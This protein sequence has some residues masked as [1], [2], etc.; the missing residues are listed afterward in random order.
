MATISSISTSVAYVLPTQDT[1]SMDF[2]PDD[3]IAV[4]KATNRSKPSNPVDWLNFK[5]SKK[6]LKEAAKN[7]QLTEKQREAA[8]AAFRGTDAFNSTTLMSKNSTNG[9]FLVRPTILLFAD[10]RL[11]N[12]IMY[13][14]Q[15]P[16]ETAIINRASLKVLEALVIKGKRAELSQNELAELTYVAALLKLPGE[17]KTLRDALKASL[18]VNNE[19]IS[20]R[21]YYI[22][23][24]LNLNLTLVNNTRIYA[25]CAKAKCC[26][27]VTDSLTSLGGELDKFEKVLSGEETK[28]WQS[29]SPLLQLRFFYFLQDEKNFQ[30][31]RLQVFSSLLCY[32]RDGQLDD[33]YVNLLFQTVKQFFEYREILKK[34]RLTLNIEGVGTMD[35]ALWNVCGMSKFFCSHLRS[36]MNKSADVIPLVGS[37]AKTFPILYE[38]W[39]KNR[40]IEVDKYSLD[41][42]VELLEGIGY[43]QIRD[44]ADVRTKIVVAISEKLGDDKLSLVELASKLDCPE[45]NEKVSELFKK[46]PF[47]VFT[48]NGKQKAVKIQFEKFPSMHAL[49]QSLPIIKFLYADKQISNIEIDMQEVP[50]G[51]DDSLFLLICH[52]CC[53]ALGLDEQKEGLEKQLL[54]LSRLETEKPVGVGKFPVFKAFDFL[55]LLEGTSDPL[56]AH[57]IKLAQE[58]SYT[59]EWESTKICLK[60][61]KPQEIRTRMGRF[62][63]IAFD[64]SGVY[65]AYLPAHELLQ[66]ILFYVGKT[67]G[68]HLSREHSLILK[69]ISKKISSCLDAKSLSPT[70][71]LEIIRLCIKLNPI[72]RNWIRKITFYL[73]YRGKKIKLPLELMLGAKNGCTMIDAGKLE[74]IDNLEPYQ[75]TRLAQTIFDLPYSSSYRAGLD[76]KD[77]KN[78]VQLLNT[79]G[80]EIKGINSTVTAYSY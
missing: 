40:Q 43:L 73:Q 56:L 20:V 71:L 1:N 74:N 47:L 3:W 17:V 15:F 52:F 38:C 34:D 18:E 60:N 80:I 33:S 5:K 39:V 26:F 75:L 22:I 69:Q 57:L 6:V 54:S 67:E 21:S 8:L 79:L 78:L 58:K 28:A 51:W 68:N 12:I 65:I 62:E 45:L 29:F 48:Q 9:H 50:S 59:S 2:N 77:Y 36:G 44:F 41:E 42:L 37:V 7:G 72:K 13:P 35:V 10:L 31:L 55:A 19:F 46:Y 4:L 53:Y 14:Q 27:S 16:G 30:E 25:H 63:E 24:W 11:W 66:F 76:K 61:G 64:T 23:K 32:V 49:K 70:S